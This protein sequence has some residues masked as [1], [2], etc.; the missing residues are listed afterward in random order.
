[1]LLSSLKK[2]LEYAWSYLDIVPGAAESDPDIHV[3]ASF[4]HDIRCAGERARKG[5]DGGYIQ[6]FVELWEEDRE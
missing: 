2:V 5:D 3:V 1:M 4:V 6:N